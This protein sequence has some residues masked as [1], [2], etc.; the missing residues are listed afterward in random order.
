MSNED[1]STLF[2][3]VETIEKY[4]LEVDLIAKKV[5]DKDG[6]E[7]SFELDEFYRNK[8]LKG[9]DDIGLTLLHEDKIL[10][11][12]NKHNINS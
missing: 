6:L 2:M 12:E 3:K 11:F 10:E 5:F 1:V 4:K 8:L 9:L 7:F